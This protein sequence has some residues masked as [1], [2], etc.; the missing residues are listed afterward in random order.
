VPQDSLLFEG[1]VLDNI[2]LNNPRA[3]I[4]AVMVAAKVAAAHEFILELE[5][6]YATVLGERG[7][8]LS[9]GQRQRV[10]LARTV[11]QGPSLLILDEATSALDAETEK[12]VCRN[13]A[14]VF[15]HATVLFI[16][17]RLTTLQRADRILFMSNG[18]II[19]DG[20]HKELLARQ[21]AYGT[22]YEQQVGEG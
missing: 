2:R 14:E 15:S 10:C 8:G 16:T 19:E 11:L 13:L 7:S 20:T 4:E 12:Q 6:G 21:G 18:R 5:N 22:L 9:G 1:S 17:H 3:D